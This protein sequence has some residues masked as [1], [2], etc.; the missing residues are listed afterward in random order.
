MADAV[1][2]AARRSA[3]VQVTPHFIGR[4]V[5]RLHVYGCCG[6]TSL[7]ICGRSWRLH[8]GY[9]SS[10][11]HT[12]NASYLRHADAIIIII[13]QHVCL[14]PVRRCRLDKR[15]CEG[16]A[17]APLI[18]TVSAN[19]CRLR[20]DADPCSMVAGKQGAAVSATHCQHLRWW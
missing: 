11:S 20:Y 1:G 15:C 9:A 18:S 14:T 8:N 2:F 16:L 17:T 12:C 5:N 7:R 10:S 13:Q 6:C 19:L 4:I 3:A